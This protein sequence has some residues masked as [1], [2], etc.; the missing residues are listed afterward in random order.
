M[1]PLEGSIIKWEKI[2]KDRRSIDNGIDNCPL[3][4][5][6]EDCES[7]L[8]KIKSGT[9]CGGTPYGEWHMHHIKIHGDGNLPLRR[10]KGCKTCDELAQKELDFLRSLLK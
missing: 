8:I 4:I 9:S 6:N 7:C 1:T 3:C 2:C 5:D 10:Q